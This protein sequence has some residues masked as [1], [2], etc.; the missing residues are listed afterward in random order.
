MTV[1]EI[2]NILK[3]RLLEDYP[4]AETQ[5]LVFLI[6][7]H[8]TGFSK[9]EQILHSDY[10]MDSAKLETALR[11]AERLKN[12]EPVQYILG[13][14]VFYGFPIHVRPG[15]LIPRRE[16]EELVDWAVK[17]LQSLNIS[18]AILD[19]ATGSGCIAIALKKIFPHAEVSGWDISDDALAVARENA[20][21]NK[22]NIHWEKRDILSCKTKQSWDVIISNP[23]YVL[24]QDKERMD[25]NVLDF[26]PAEALFI[27]DE[28]ALR[29]YESI[30]DFAGEHLRNDG[31]LFLEIHEEKG[32]EIKSLLER[33]DFSDVSIKKDMQNKPRMVRARK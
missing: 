3:D 29:F 32:N 25:S 4:Y 6:I 28:D 8:F 21:T 11:Y 5:Q 17:S 23:P 15:V 14:T 24:E 27:P 19:I 26:E 2:K 9:S 20:E 13:E 7:E 12:R 31:F 10:E 18:P 30:A 16:T 33:H 22:T 1:K